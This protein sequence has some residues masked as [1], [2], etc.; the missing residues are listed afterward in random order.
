MYDLGNQ[1]HFDLNKAKTN[2]DSIL[3]GNNYR[4]SVL[5]E[6][7]VRIEYSKNGLFIDAPTQLVLCRNFPVPKF[8]VNEDSKYIELKTEYFKLT[9]KKNNPITSSSLK[10]QPTSSDDFWYYKHPEVRTYDASLVSLD[11]EKKYIKGIFS[12][13]GFSSID[14]SNSLLLDINGNFVKKQSN[15]LDIYVFVYKDDFD[16]ALK[17]YFALTG[18]APLIPRYALGNWWSK[19]YGYKEAT[20]DKLFNRFEKEEIPIYYMFSHITFSYRTLLLNQCACYQSHLSY[21]LSKFTGIAVN[22]S[23]VGY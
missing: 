17:D 4:I 1:F 10:I 16:L 14:D 2:P 13:S 8:D 9:Y 19:N 6:R 15:S 3:T 21:I 7:L 5:T 18:R 20:L 11:S 12:S 23:R 22:N